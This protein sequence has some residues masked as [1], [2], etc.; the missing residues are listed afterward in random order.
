MNVWNI[1]EHLKKYPD[2]IGILLN[3]CNFH[4]IS[5]KSVEYRCGHSEF[6]TP[7]SIRVNTESLSA[8]WYSEGIEGD[9]ITLVQHRQN[10]SF[11]QTLKFIMSTLGLKEESFSYHPT[12]L[13]Y[14]GYYKSITKTNELDFSIPIINYTDIPYID[15]FP[16][17]MF[18]DDGISIDVQNKFLIGYHHLTG[19]ISI[20]WWDSSGNLVGMMG[21]YNGDANDID[22]KYM[23]L[24]TSGSNVH[25]FPKGKT[26]YGYHI[27][28]TDILQKGSVFVVESEKAVMQLATMGVHNA[29]ALGGNSI[30]VYQ[31]KLLHSLGVSIIYCPDEGLKME[32]IQKVMDDLKSDNPF[33]PIKVFLMIDRDNKYM[34]KD[35][36]LSPT[37]Q[38]YDIFVELLKNCIEQW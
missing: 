35:S 15:Y 7:T 14:G 1:K 8:S 2:K 9:I 3:A 32:I 17:K 21:R 34:G 23:P 12:K 38:G 33:L 4:N 28:Y 26:L 37:D 29:V 20:P 27:N 36:H 22:N 24:P 30:S 5:C 10:L 25:G 31:L 11:P 6:S 19:R 16:N 13:P 18:L